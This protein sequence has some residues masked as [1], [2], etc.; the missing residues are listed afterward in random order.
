MFS[1]LLGWL[2]FIK[3]TFITLFLLIGSIFGLLGVWMLAYDMSSPLGWMT[4]MSGLMCFYMLLL[5]LSE[6]LPDYSDDYADEPL[7]KLGQGSSQ[8]EID[9]EVNKYCPSL[10]WMDNEDKKSPDVW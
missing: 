1:C 6:W 7:V 3:R 10:D 9:A 2:R 8:T 5:L 4:A